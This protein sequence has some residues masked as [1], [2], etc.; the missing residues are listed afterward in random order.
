VGFESI[1]FGSDCFGGGDSFFGSG[2]FSCAGGGVGSS[3]GFDSSFFESSG[4]DE[5]DW[6]LVAGSLGSEAPF[7]FS[8]PE[9]A[10]PSSRR[11]KSCPTVTVSSSFA[12]NSLIVPASGALTATS[13]WGGKGQRS[14]SL[15]TARPRL[16]LSVSI[17]AIS[18]SCSTKSPICFDHC[19]RVPSEID[20]AISGTLTIL[21][22]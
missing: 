10:P 12:R 11:T 22:A 20:S 8:P 3:F 21:S 15:Q 17:V 5:V 13:I 9:G 2:F 19:F 4:F 7:S 16:T 14:S 6:S 1:F 18:S